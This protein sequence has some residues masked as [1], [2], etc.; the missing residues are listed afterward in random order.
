MDEIHR[1]ILNIENEEIIKQLEE[2]NDNELM[3]LLSKNAKKYLVN[4]DFLLREVAGE[5]LLIPTG[6]SADS[7]N[8][9]VSLNESFYYIWKQFEEPHTIYEVVMSAKEEYEDPSG[10]IAKDIYRF[11]IESMKMN[12][13]REVK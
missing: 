8:G 7:I 1:P 10:R 11:V 5:Y 6:S 12:F 2:L 9:M 3:E 13:I 4:P